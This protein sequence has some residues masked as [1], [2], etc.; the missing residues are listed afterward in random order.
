MKIYDLLEKSDWMAIPDFLRG[1]A[2]GMSNKSEF[3]HFGRE[4]YGFVSKYSEY[5]HIMGLNIEDRSRVWRKVR[6][7]Q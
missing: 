6:G 4:F 2:I 5:A 7:A 3:A 1:K